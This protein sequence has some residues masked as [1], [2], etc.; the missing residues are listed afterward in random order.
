MP[1]LRGRAHR[2]Q[3]AGL[4]RARAAGRG[5]D[6]RPLP[7]PGR[8]AA[9]RPGD[10]GGQVGLLAVLAGAAGRQ[11]RQPARL[12]PGADRLRRLVSL[13][14]ASYNYWIAQSA[15][16]PARS[17]CA[18]PIPRAT[19][20]PC[21]TSPST[22]ARSSP[23]AST[24]TG[25]GSDPGHPAAA[26]ASTAASPTAR[27]THSAAPARASSSV[28]PA[29]SGQHPGAGGGAR[30]PADDSLSRSRPPLADHPHGDRIQRKESH[31]IRRS[32][33]KGGGMRTTME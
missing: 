31:S 16:A 25:A 11:H 27:A 1:G 18:S 30:A 2:P 26:S 21:T 8:P 4:R 23:P 32:N 28:S 29:R 33:S 24:C 19:R 14:R 3:R 7:R 5:A 12:G 20:S 6:Q 17:P 9:A 10:D 15:R 22:P 13:A